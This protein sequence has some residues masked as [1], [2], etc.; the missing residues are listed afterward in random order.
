MTQS[1]C[2]RSSVGT[3]RSSGRW[4]M[5]VWSTDQPG[6]IYGFQFFSKHFLR[7]ILH[8]VSRPRYFRSHWYLLSERSV[9]SSDLFRLE[10]GYL[11]L[12]MKTL[13][14]KQS[15]QFRRTCQKAPVSARLQY[16]DLL[17]Q[18]LTYSAVS[19]QPIFLIYTILIA[20]RW[21]G[22][23]LIQ[24]RSISIGWG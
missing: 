19:Q 6:M 14:H 2:G 21:C 13:L 22:D 12:Y 4:E 8:P 24:V 11:I 23:R 9:M 18:R 20:S 1:Y 16:C 7:N 10:L 17:I 5:P 3:W 15:D